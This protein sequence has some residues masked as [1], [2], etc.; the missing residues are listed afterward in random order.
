MRLVY[1]CFCRGFFLDDSYGH[2]VAV[3]EVLTC[4]VEIELKTNDFIKVEDVMSIW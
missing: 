3:Y 4:V 2:V 1:F